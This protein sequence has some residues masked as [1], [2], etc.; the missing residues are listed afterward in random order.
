MPDSLVKHETFCEALIECVKALGGS[1]RVGVLMKPSR[2]IEDSARWV[3]DC[4]NL[5]R[6]ERFEPEE[7]LWLMREARRVGCHAAMNYL[8]D[9]T[10]YSQ[11]TPV[12]PADEA[13]E[14]QRAFIESVRLQQQLITRMEA[15]GTMSPGA[16]L[17]VA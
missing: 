17:K 16:R 2:S 3:R 8:A 7:V 6:R 12:E 11:P 4:L 5:E 14:L 9:A 1:K 13:G 10:G 15:M